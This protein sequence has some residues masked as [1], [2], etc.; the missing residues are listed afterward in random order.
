MVQQSKKELSNQAAPKSEIERDLD[1]NVVFSLHFR[2]AVY[3]IS[4]A[5]LLILGSIW[6]WELAAYLILFV[7]AGGVLDLCHLGGL[8]LSVN[9]RAL[10]FTFTL[11]HVGLI[12]IAL[13]VIG[14]LVGAPDEV[15]SHGILGLLLGPAPI[16]FFA[17]V[18]FSLAL[19]VSPLPMWS[20][21]AGSIV[22]LGLCFAGVF[23]A[24][25]GPAPHLNGGANS[26]STFAPVL[27]ASVLGVCLLMGS[28]IVGWRVLLRA[29][30]QVKIADIHQRRRDLLSQF[31]PPDL[32]GRLSELD[33]V[34]DSISECEC[35]VLLVDISH[36]QR[37]MDSVT[38]VETGLLIQE[39]HELVSRV[40][41]KNGGFLQQMEGDSLY[42][43]FGLL[44]QERKC[45]EQAVLCAQTMAEA[46]R[47]WRSERIDRGKTPADLFMGVD[48]GRCV[49]VPNADPDRADFSMAGAPFGAARRMERVARLVATDLAMTGHAV[50][51]LKEDTDGALCSMMEHRGPQKVDD[52]RGVVDV[53][54]WSLPL[55]HQMK[56]GSVA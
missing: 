27:G 15:A 13:I 24:G 28:G 17:A 45:V 33:R 19:G 35:A 16:L 47:M 10:A 49:I 54:T 23:V 11:A 9:R 1:T 50:H 12:G 31:V 53:L 48:F 38:L 20:A 51:R 34:F 2:L 37:T 6:Q 30:Q 32:V 43:I 55:A 41:F 52:K 25:L 56:V 14:G 26:L 7:A 39:F 18:A 3:A 29:G 5:G 22:W 8:G 21:T 42:A 46:A 36:F 40:V 44:K 4:A